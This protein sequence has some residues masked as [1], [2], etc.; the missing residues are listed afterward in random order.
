[1][2]QGVKV[3]ATLAKEPSSVLCS[4]LT[5]AYN[6]ICCRIILPYTEYVL[7][8]LVN[9]EQGYNL[10]SSADTGNRR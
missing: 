5:T 4:Q 10:E 3:L 6:S 2:T 9:K 8:S 1:M 7:L